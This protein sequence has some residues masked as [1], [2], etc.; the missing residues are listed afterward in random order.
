MYTMYHIYPFE[1]RK[2]HSR[3]YYGGI[4][5]I[6]NM[7]TLKVSLQLSLRKEKRW[8]V[9]REGNFPICLSRYLM[10]KPVQRRASR[11]VLWEVTL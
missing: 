10:T 4:P 8:A 1:K 3:G 5:V 9:I 7:L 11:D 6:I 2:K